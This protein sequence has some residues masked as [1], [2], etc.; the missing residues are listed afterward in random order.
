MLRHSAGM[1]GQASGTEALVAADLACVPTRCEQARRNLGNITS[2]G[3]TS[4][5]QLGD[6]PAAFV[7]QAPPGTMRARG[8]RKRRLVV[9]PPFF[10][11]VPFLLR[12][13]IS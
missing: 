3:F 9:Y 12:L 6:R 10:P 8:S 11:W 1:F 4:N 13:V 2:G 7:A 5:S